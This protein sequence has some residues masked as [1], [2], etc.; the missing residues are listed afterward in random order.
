VEGTMTIGDT[1]VSSPLGTF[2]FTGVHN[3]ATGSLTL[4]P[5]TWTEY[6]RSVLTFFIHGRYDTATGA[7]D[8]DQLSNV[9]VCPRDMWATVID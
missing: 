9:D 5:G 4:V 7:Y 3:P 6:T 1:D 8:G 2:G